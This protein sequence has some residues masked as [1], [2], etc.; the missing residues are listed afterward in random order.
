[1]YFRAKEA[2]RI[3]VQTFQIKC[4]SEQNLSISGIDPVAWAQINSTLTEQP[5]LLGGFHVEMHGPL[6]IGSTRDFDILQLRE[7]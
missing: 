2:P 7:L 4:N 1:M 3:D 5:S 6:C